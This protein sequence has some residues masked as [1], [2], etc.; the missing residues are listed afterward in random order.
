MATSQDGPDPTTETLSAYLQRIGAVPLLRADEEVDLAKR[1]A[2]GRA[3]ATLVDAGTALPDH[4]RLVADGKRAYERLVTANLRLVVSV[5][6]RYR[7]PGDDLVT[8]VQDGN[9]GLLVAAGRFDPARGYR[10]STYATHWIRQRIA[11]APDERVGHVRLPPGA[12]QQLRRIA[13]ADQQLTATRCR[14]PQLD[15][16][17]AACGMRAGRVAE[18][19]GAARPSV[20]IGPSDH[21]PDRPV[22]ELVADTPDPAEVATAPAVTA[23]LRAALATLERRDREVLTLRYGLDG[24]EPRTY[25]E[26]AGRLGLSRERV[27][28]LELRALHRLRQQVLP[29]FDEGPARAGTLAS[30]G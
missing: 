8:L 3:A 7:R 19:L 23:E 12:H 13:L 22:L 5:A 2:A 20:P 6:R 30:V 15:E 28:Q 29:P 26:V 21:E 17:A 27:R 25:A 4:L 14:P 24:G 10:F 9:L 18:L 1:I 11:R 16:L